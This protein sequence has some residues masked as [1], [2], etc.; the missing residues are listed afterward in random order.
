MNGLRNKKAF[1]AA[2]TLASFCIFVSAASA[3]PK[4]WG[5]EKYS[6]LEQKKYD[7]EYK[8]ERI[9]IL[10][11]RADQKVGGYRAEVIKARLEHQQDEIDYKIK[12]IERRQDRIQ[13][14]VRDRYRPRYHPRGSSRYYNNNYNRPRNVYYS[15][16]TGNVGVRDYRYRPRCANDRRG[17]G[18]YRRY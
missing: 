2:A 5:W 13:N 15:P 3:A 16:R 14:R 17:S 7:L 8:K 4:R 6:N 10:Q 1:L 18:Y 11:D 9:E 12:N